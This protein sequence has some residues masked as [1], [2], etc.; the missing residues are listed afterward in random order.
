MF[1]LAVRTSA[2]SATGDVSQDVL[3]NPVL[4]ARLDAR[5]LYSDDRLERSLS[6]EVRILHVERSDRVRTTV[7]R[8]TYGSETFEVTAGVDDARH[9]HSGPEGYVNTLPPELFAQSHTP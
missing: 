6:G 7:E 4:S 1:L 9:V 5:R 3:V 2:E 8:Q